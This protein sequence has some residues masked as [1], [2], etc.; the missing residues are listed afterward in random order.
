MVRHRNLL[1]LL[2][3]SIILTGVLVAIRP[4]AAE[5]FAVDSCL[6]GWRSCFWRT[7]CLDVYAMGQPAQVQMS[8]EVV[9]NGVATSNLA[10][11]AL[12]ILSF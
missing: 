5:F 1:R 11:V 6:G 10:A 9:E 7:G 8:V 12:I 4:R 2:G 3:V